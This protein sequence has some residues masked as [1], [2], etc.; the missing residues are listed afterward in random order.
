MSRPGPW[1][2]ATCNL[3]G[4]CSHAGLDCKYC[5]AQLEAGT[6]HTALRRELYEGTTVWIRGRPVFNGKM[7]ELP[8]THPEWKKYLTWRGVEHPVMGP[9]KPSLLWFNDTSDLFHEERPER[10]IH[11]VVGTAVAIPDPHISL[12]LTKRAQR[13]NEYFRAWRVDRMKSWRRKIWLGFSAG[14]QRWFDSRWLHWRELSAREWTVF[15]SLA[16]LLG[17][18]KLP[19]DFLAL[20]NRGWVI[21]NG[22]YGPRYRPMDVEWARALRQQCANARVPFLF[23]DMAGKKPVPPDLFICRQFPTVLP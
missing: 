17:P 23:Y 22:E 4:G 5:W 19:P 14:D 18:I 7:T 9:G 15:V 1:W 21:V 11:Q 10:V 13:M 3:C 8:P 12:L 2:D 16:P 6:L 20:G